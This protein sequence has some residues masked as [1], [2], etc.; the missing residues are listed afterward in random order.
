VELTLLVGA[1]AQSYFLNGS[2][3]VTANVR[4]WRAQL[5]EKLALPHP[6]PRNIAWFKTNPWFERDVLPA[7][8][9]RVRKVLGE[10]A[11]SD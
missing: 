5:P 3:D 7:L 11:R 9:W 10:R 2:A 4:A 1:Y 6:S 8:R